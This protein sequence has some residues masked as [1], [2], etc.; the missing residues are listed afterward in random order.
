MEILLPI[1]NFIDHVGMDN[2]TETSVK[3]PQES[4]T[5]DYKISKKKNPKLMK[6]CWE[7]NRCYG[8]PSIEE[9]QEK[10]HGDDES[11]DILWFFI[12]YTMYLQ[13]VKDCDMKRVKD[14]DDC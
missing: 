3:D 7:T 11:F 14:C 4:W 6:Y 12:S 10:T 13:R 9:Y 8:N 2:N 5:G 1:I